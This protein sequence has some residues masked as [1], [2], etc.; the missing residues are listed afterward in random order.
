MESLHSRFAKG[1][2]D[3]ALA[4]C[5]LVLSCQDSDQSSSSMSC[6]ARTP[7]DRHSKQSENHDGVHMLLVLIMNNT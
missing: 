5:L 6:S 1:L 7:A 4:M 3:M 2:F